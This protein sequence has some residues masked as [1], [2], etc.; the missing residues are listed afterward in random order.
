MEFLK[1][2]TSTHT[3]IFQETIRPAPTSS[4]P[5][6]VADH[7]PPRQLKLFVVSGAMKNDTE[8]KKKAVGDG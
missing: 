4:S 1:H 6:P 8:R 2:T 7:L 3:Q 5:T